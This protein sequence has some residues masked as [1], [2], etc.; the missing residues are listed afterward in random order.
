[1][2]ALGPEMYFLALPLEKRLKRRKEGSRGGEI[3]CIICM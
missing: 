2:S 3:K 1:M